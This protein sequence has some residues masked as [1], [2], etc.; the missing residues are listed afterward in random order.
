M[1]KTLNYRRWLLLAAVF[2]FPIFV[3][4]QEGGG[5]G[6]G[7]EGG[8]SGSSTATTPGSSKAQKRKAKKEWKKNRATKL[9]AERQQR[10]YNKIYNTKATRKRMKRSRKEAER[11]NHHK[12]DPF[13]KRWF[14]K[15]H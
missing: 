7:G 5:G 15:K 14:R 12:G 13:Y 1:K 2:L 4:A 9:D 6:G 10:E 3:M 11:N 8:G